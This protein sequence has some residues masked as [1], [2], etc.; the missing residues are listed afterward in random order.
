MVGWHHRLSGPEFEQALRDS[1][2]QGSPACYIQS[3]G[4]QR[5]GHDLATEW[6]QL[7]VTV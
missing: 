2:G 1:E 4:S 7:S 6:Q 5:V 3:M